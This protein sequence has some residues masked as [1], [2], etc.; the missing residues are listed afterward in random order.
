MVSVFQQIV[1]LSYVNKD[2]ALN[3]IMF[4]VVSLIFLRSWKVFCAEFHI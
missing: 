3:V 2:D 1:F 4:K